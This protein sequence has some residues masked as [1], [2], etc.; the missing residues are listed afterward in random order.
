MHKGKDKWLEMYLS[1]ETCEIA[2]KILK[3]IVSYKV[4]EPK[5]K[6]SYFFIIITSK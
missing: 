6:L 2:I 1:I 4:I 3:H 5:Y